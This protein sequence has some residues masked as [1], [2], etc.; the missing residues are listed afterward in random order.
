MVVA[1]VEV[2]VAAVEVPVAEEVVAVAAAVV[3]WLRWRNRRGKPRRWR[4]IRGTFVDPR[5]NPRRSLMRSRSCLFLHPWGAQ[6]PVSTGPYGAD[7]GSG[8][9]VTTII[10]FMTGCG[11]Q[12]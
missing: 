6:T 8:A 10:A 12:W 4:G 11:M 1:A 5:T 3:R 7:S 2:A 9:D